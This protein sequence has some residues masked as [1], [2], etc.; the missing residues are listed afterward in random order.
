[1]A[2]FRAAPYAKALHDVA[3]AGDPATAASVLKEIEAIAEA[4]DMVPEL[5]RAMVVPTVTPEIKTQILDEVMTALGVGDTVRRFVHVVQ[6]H[7]RM[8]H[9]ADIVT[10]YR[11]LSDRAAGRVRAAVQVVGAIDEGVRQ[12][13]VDTMT[14]LTGATVIA[15]F[16]NRPE[17][18][19]GFRIQVGSKVFDGSLQA[20]LDRLRRQ[21]I[22]E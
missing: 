11:E 16:E 5:G 17:L 18:L 19:A 20:Q 22:I 6:Q 13:V 7:Y 21:T 8:E 9:M 1:M 10:A 12:N 14:R 2:R 3:S 15:A 4:L